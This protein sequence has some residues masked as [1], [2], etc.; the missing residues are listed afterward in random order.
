MYADYA[1]IRQGEFPQLPS[2]EKKLRYYSQVLM[3]LIGNAVKFT[4]NGHVRVNC[5]AEQQSTASSDT[6]ALLKF[7]VL[8][9]DL[10]LLPRTTLS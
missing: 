1:R 2:V 8:S 5:S 6:M 10:L 4:A 9:V 7:D 3:N